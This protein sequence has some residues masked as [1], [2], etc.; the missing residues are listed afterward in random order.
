[1]S[2]KSAG[3]NYLGIELDKSI[4]G[5]IIWRKELTD[6]II[7][8][9]ADDVKYLEQIRI[10]QLELLSEKGLLTAIDYENRFIFP[11]AYCEYCG[12]KLDV[13]KW[14]AKMQ[15]DI[16]KLN[17]CLSLLND[18]VVQ[19]FPNN[20]Q[21][22]YIN[23]QG[24]LFDGFNTNPQC[25][26]NWNSAKQVIPL[27]EELGFNLETQ[28]RA[29][30]EIKK[31]VDAKIIKPQKH[32]SSIAPIYLEYRAAQKVVSTYGENF[33]VQINP[34]SHRIHT[35]YQQ[36]GADTTRITSGGKDKGDN[37]EYINFLNLPKD[38]ETRACIVAEKDNKWI[39]LDYSSQETF[40]LASIADDK[41]IIKELTEGS[42]DI[43]ECHPI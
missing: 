16:N 21:Y 13:D 17:T 18:W 14:K 4:R 37:I 43:M 25:T 41:A 30:G 2:L 24:S 19:H 40:L 1:M 38:E 12:I 10:K 23:L 28:D 39:S 9:S 7:K 8:Y 20:K 26:I 33:L 36:L 34:V 6:E 3:I 31:S 22:T 42:G 11:L 35:N 32:L 29:T 5:Q 27:F 15:K